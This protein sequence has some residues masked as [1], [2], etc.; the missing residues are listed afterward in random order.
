MKYFLVVWNDSYPKDFFDFHISNDV[1]EVAIIVFVKSS[2]RFVFPSFC[3]EVVR[4]L[5]SEGGIFANIMVWCSSKFSSSYDDVFLFDAGNSPEKWRDLSK[6]IESSRNYHY[7]TLNI[8]FKTSLKQ[9]LIE[10]FKDSFCDKCKILFDGSYSL[11]NH[12]SRDCS[13]CNKPECDG[14]NHLRLCDSLCKEVG[15]SESFYCCQKLKIDNHLKE[16]P[17]CGVC[18]KKF[19]DSFSKERHDREELCN[20]CRRMKCTDSNPSIHSEVWTCDISRCT[21][22]SPKCCFTKDIK[23]EHLKS[24]PKCTTCQT[25]YN[26]STEL[27]SHVNINTCS[28]CKVLKCGKPEAHRLVTFQACTDIDCSY[29]F[30]LCKQELYTKTH[31]ENH[32]ECSCGCGSRVFNRSELHPRDFRCKDC[33]LTFSNSEEWLNHDDHILICPVTG[34]MPPAN[35]YGAFGNVYYA[36]STA[37]HAH[38]NYVDYARCYHSKCSTVNKYFAK[39]SKMCDHLDKFAFECDECDDVYFLRKS[40]LEAHNKNFHA[41]DDSP[42]PPPAKSVSGSS[43]RGGTKFQLFGMRRNKC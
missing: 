19:R 18:L 40:L 25:L 2:C 13:S 30:P 36:A 23:E 14:G 37:S 6:M 43:T 3:K 8:V 34:S 33:N 7:S 22:R 21:F 17:K 12:R 20:H 9:T 35:F 29:Q 39:Y 28:A 10:K 16:H 15:C 42:P 26:S 1:R 11:R 24:H 4:T 27:T 38:A 41:K 5:D 31:L 32:P